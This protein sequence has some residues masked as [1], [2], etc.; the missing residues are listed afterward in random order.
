[1]PRS[2]HFEAVDF[3]HEAHDVF[4][5]V[6]D[7]AA[8][9]AEDHFA[10]LLGD[11]GLGGQER[12]EDLADLTQHLAAHDEFGE[13]VGAFLIALTHHLHGFGGE[14]QDLV[15]VFAFGEQVV[16]DLKGFFFLHVRHG[17]YEFVGHWGSFP[18]PGV[19]T[20]PDLLDSPS[21]RVLFTASRY[22]PIRRARR[23]PLP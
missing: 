16:D 14:I 4:A 21:N 20:H 15:G 19:A 13:E 6:V 3:Q 9:G 1:M 7:V 2:I 8:D 22:G 17:F 11:A 10:Q 23:A 5:D 18:F 12:L